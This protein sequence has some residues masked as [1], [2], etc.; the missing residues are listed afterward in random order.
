MIDLTTVEL[1][2]SEEV[3]RDNEDNATENLAFPGFPYNSNFLELSNGLNMHYLDEGSGDP[4]VLLHGQPTSSYL[5]RNII[6]ELAERGRVIVPDLINFGLSDKTDEP[7]NVVS[8]HGALFSEFID[9]LGIEDVTLVGHDWGGPIELAYAVDNPDNVKALAFFE[10]AIVPFPDVSVASAF[11]PQF[12]QAFWSDPDLLEQN[13]IDNNLFI[14]GWLFD[15]AFG[16]I[17]NPLTEADKEVY[18]EPFLDPES[19][20]QL[21]IAPRQLPFLDP[22][23]FPI[24]DPDGPGGDPPEQATD[25]EAYIEFTNYL[26]T[27]EVPKLLIY[28]NPGFASPEFVLSLAD[29]IPG[30]ETQAIGDADN[31]VYHFIQEDAPEE[32]SAILGEWYDTSVAPPEPEP[33]SETRKIQVTVENL[34]PENGVGFAAL[35]FGLHDGSFDTF[36]PGDEASKS[37]EFLFED[38]LVGLEEGEEFLPGILDEI[39]AAGVDINELPLSVQQALALGLDLSTLPPPSGT[40]AGD[41]LSSDAGANGG[42][43][44]MVVTSIRTNPEL[45]DLLDDPSAFPQDVLD[46]ITNPY[47]F[48]QASGETETF[49]VEL[50]GTPEQNRYFSFASMLFPTNDG[51]IGNE[52]PQAIE[53]FN[54]SGDFIGADFIVTGEDTWDGGTEVNDESPESLLYTFEVFG[55]GEDENGT[56]Q[57]FPGFK[58]AGDGGALD[59]EFNG[60]LVSENAD[61]TVPDYPIARITVTE[62]TEPTEP[63]TPL[64][65]V[66][67]LT[68]L[69][70][71]SVTL[72]IARDAFFNNVVDLYE[73]NADGSVTDET[74][75]TI[76]LGEA[77]YQQAAIANRLG[78]DLKT[79]NRQT[80][81]FDAVLE[82]D[83]IYA[84]LIVVNGEFAQLDDLDSS[85]DP[86]VFFGF[87]E[88][89][90]DNFD[91]IKTLEANSFGFED[92]VGGGDADFNDMTLTI[93]GLDVPETPE[94]EPEPNVGT[95]EADIIEVTGSNGL[96]FAGGGNDLVDASASEGDNRIFGGT[97]DDTFI[98]GGGDVLTGG[99]GEDRFFNQAAGGDRLTGGAD[100]DQF[101]IAVA[102]IP[103]QAL[104][105]TD[106][107]LDLD[108]IGIRGI[109]A[110]S[111]ADL[112]FTQ[113]GNDA[114]IGFNGTDL[115]VLQE[116]DASRLEGDGT[117]VF[118]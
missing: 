107:E 27:T 70:D 12:A 6:P 36:D 90:V 117:F 54:E 42:T 91:H 79:A 7:L 40:L 23:G 94:P 45:F 100:A 112:S 52:D 101:W 2:E 30:F 66:L 44:G 76:A 33:P 63:E 87:A 9:T 46:S 73:I 29:A 78:L 98:L 77:G 108:V 14:E 113:N 115:A 24:L 22:T 83:K 60:K 89:N 116:V 11:P 50:E 68:G 37:L 19:R 74:G 88:A 71:R 48:I 41:F 18:R 58:A 97:G 84:P 110:T 10:S 21:A 56:I 67:D 82:G 69:G 102:E 118:A 4:I 20:E 65:D 47:F 85:N 32:L 51:F 80:T 72:T 106:F 96:I 26:A 81:E 5:W 109:G 34:A 62:V 86:F 25:I 59:F 111:T 55:K 8:D 64:E 105:I 38:G 92:L 95:T 57:P 99:T 13:A 53:I 28:G 16:G 114:V 75:V 104:T 17:A 15:P 103:E 1:A 43:Q 61:F 49:T 31:P 3:S 35:W 93:S 39:I